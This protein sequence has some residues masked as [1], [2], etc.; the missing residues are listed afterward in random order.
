MNC[1]TAV[2]ALAVQMVMCVINNPLQALCCYTAEGILFREVVHDW[3]SMPCRC[4]SG[5]CGQVWQAPPAADRRRGHVWQ[6]AAHRH[7]LSSCIQ[8]CSRNIHHHSD[9]VHLR[10]LISGDFPSE[11]LGCPKQTASELCC[12]VDNRNLLYSAC[13]YTTMTCKALS[14]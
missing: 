2:M 3:Q 10:G 13:I 6:H 9:A 8:Q 14:L 12:Q 1:G 11:P 4:R 7:C 5:D